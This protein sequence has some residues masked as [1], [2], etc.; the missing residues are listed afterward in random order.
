MNILF[1]RALQKCNPASLTLRCQS[2]KFLEAN[3][4]LLKF[5]ANLFSGTKSLFN[6]CYN[7]GERGHVLSQCTAVKNTVDKNKYVKC[8]KC[9]KQGHMANDCELA[10]ESGKVCHNCQEKGH[11]SK[12]CSKPVVITCFNCGTKGHTLKNCPSKVTVTKKK[13]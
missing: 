13:I 7:C 4:S 8:Y 6:V 3:K 10:N 2:L 11:E 12:N 5:Q 1:S 9:G